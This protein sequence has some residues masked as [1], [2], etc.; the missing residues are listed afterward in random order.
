MKK[1]LHLKS[2]PSS[3]SLF[4]PAAGMR[5]RTSPPRHGS[6]PYN[7]T[8]LFQAHLEALGTID[9]HEL[10]GHPAWEPLGTCDHRQNIHHPHWTHSLRDTW[11]T[12]SEHGP[13]LPARHCPPCWLGFPACMEAESG[14]RRSRKLQSRTLGGSPRTCR[15]LSM[16][17][18]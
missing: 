10:D 3:S 11:E 9:F 18:G 6:R 12:V 4:H 14:N 15:N 8:W 16:T 5:C 1:V 7:W 17:F 2:Q 13:Q